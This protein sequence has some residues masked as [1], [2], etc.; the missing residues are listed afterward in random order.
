MKRLLL[1]IAAYLEWRCVNP[2]T[3]TGFIF[4]VEK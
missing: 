4:G 2:E 3:E 1:A